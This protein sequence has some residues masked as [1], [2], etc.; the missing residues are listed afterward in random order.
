MNWQ[1]QALVFLDYAHSVANNTT[2][3]QKYKKSLLDTLLRRAS[4]IISSEDIKVHNNTA[5]NI[6]HCKRWSKAAVEQYYAERDRLTEQRNGRPPTHRQLCELR[7]E[8][9]KRL[10]LCEH[11]YP[12]LIPKTKLLEGCSFE[13]ISNWMF[14]Y[15]YCTII[16]REEDANLLLT[17]L[18]ESVA[19]ER[20]KNA[21]ITIT[22]HPEL[23]HANLASNG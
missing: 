17:T 11:R 8:N 15:G 7:D 12:L 18:D 13:E 9:G 22:I 2:L 10:W 14:E 3:L 20:Y 6:Q 4:D 19:K 5:S 16:K 23:D 21:G 1:D